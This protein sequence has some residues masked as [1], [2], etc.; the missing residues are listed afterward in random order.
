MNAKKYIS[1]IIALATIGSIALISPAF[2]VSV[3]GNNSEQVQ[4]SAIVGTVSAINGKNGNNVSAKMI[5]D[6]QDK[7]GRTDSNSMMPAVVGKVSVINGNVLTVV[8]QQGASNTTVTFTVDATNAK[9]L[10]GN[11]TITLSGIAVGDNIVVQGILTGTNVLATI[12]RDGKVGNGNSKGSVSDN[13]QAL[14]QIQGNGQPIIGGTISAINGSTLTVTNNS[15]VVYAVD[16]TNA[17]IVQGTNTILLSGIK[18]GDS[19]IVQ[20]TVSGTSVTASTIIDSNTTTHS[21]FFTSIG[22]WFRHLFGF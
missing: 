13:N 3:Q 19:V 2:A 9:L 11:T 6:G 15:D 4:A 22:Q 17:K 8:S 7:Q 10:R 14:L 16:A 20:G 5:S 18:I 12:I 1:L 21:G